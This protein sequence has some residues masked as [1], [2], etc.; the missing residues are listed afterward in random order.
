LEEAFGADALAGMHRLTQEGPA[1]AGLADELET[2]ERLFDGA[3]ATARHEL[4]MEAMPGDEEAARRFAGWRGTLAEDRDVGRDCRMMVPVFFDL[5]RRQT[6]VWAFLGWRAVPVDVQ[7]QTEPAVLGV[8]REQPADPEPTDRF[9]LLKRK[10]RSRPEPQPMG[11]PP[12]E[13]SGERY[14]FAVPVMAEVYVSRLLDREEFR[15]HCDRH[16][17]RDA[18]LANLV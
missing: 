5:Q 17:T 9:A 14:E 18:I 16:G 15:S 12:V 8:E 2:V 13:F 3:A 4:G 1:A 10:F 6:K 7:F 11:P